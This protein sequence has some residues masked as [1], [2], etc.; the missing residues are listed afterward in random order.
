MRRVML[1]LF[2]ALML[3]TAGSVQAATVLQKD[4]LTYKIK[5]DWQIQFRQDG[6]VDQDLDLEYDD[7]EIKNTIT[8]DLGNGISAFG[9]LDFS[10]NG[11]ADD[12]SSSSDKLEEAYL[13]FKVKD[14]KFL[15]GKTDNA[16]DEFG[17]EVAYESYGIGDDAFDELGDVG[18]DDLIMVV[19]EI[20]GMLEIRASHELEAESESSDADG[21]HTELFTALSFGSAKVAAAYQMVEESGSDDVMTIWGVQASYDFKV[22][23]IGFDYGVAEHDLDT[24]EDGVILNVSLEAP[25]GPVALGAG[26]QV[27][28]PDYDGS[29]EDVAAWY[30]NLTY[31]MQAA[32]N[33]SVFAEIGDCDIDDYDM[34]YLVGMRI[35]F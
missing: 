4:N 29:D 6:G 33:V 22:V 9:Q 2:I 17:V 30:A 27:F 23:K 18:G 34:G 14:W 35:K 1:V 24:V 28:E 10:F 7:L 20:G 19:G 5:G 12:S 8:Y 31:K 13:G 3:A 16:A 15:V 25:V 26:Y 21:T 32:K 11:A